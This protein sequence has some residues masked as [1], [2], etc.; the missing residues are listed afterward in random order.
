[1]TAA[2][3]GDRIAGQTSRH[4]EGLNRNRRIPGVMARRPPLN[5]WS[6]ETTRS[7]CGGSN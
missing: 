5:A 6:C 2:R 7:Q 3:V 4:A 1:V